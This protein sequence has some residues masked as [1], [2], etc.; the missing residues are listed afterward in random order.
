MSNKN[1]LPEK[2]TTALKAGDVQRRHVAG[3][4]FAVV[5]SYE[6]DFYRVRVIDTETGRKVSGH[7]FM[8]VTDARRSFRAAIHSVA[9][10]ET[11]QGMA[12]APWASFKSED[13]HDA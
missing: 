12:V 5:L 9:S 3:T 8:Y 2:L 4:R 10:G 7:G 11:G 13:K 6:S 1:T